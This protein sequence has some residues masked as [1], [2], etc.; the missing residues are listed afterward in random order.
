MIL[1][2]NSKKIYSSFLY[3]AYYVIKN[4]NELND[5]NYFP[6]PDGDTGTNLSSLMES[7]INKSIEEV[8]VADTLATISDAALIGSKGNSGLIFS[9]FIY[10]FTKVSDKEEMDQNIFIKAVK[11]GFI[12]AYQSIEKPVEGTMISAMRSF[13]ESLERNQDLGIDF[14]KNIELSFDNLKNEVSK[15]KEK[16]SNYKKNNIEDAGAKGFYYFIEG[17]ISVLFMDNVDL[18][19]VRSLKKIVDLPFSNEKDH[20]IDVTER[21]CT[22]VLIRTNASKHDVYK[23]V[24]DLGNSLVIGESRTIKRIHL[25]TNNPSAVVNKLEAFGEVLE[26]KIDDMKLQTLNSGQKKKIGLLVDSIADIP[27]DILEKNDVFIY[28]L[29]ILI[30]NHTYYDKLTIDNDK[31]YEVMDKSSNYPKSSSPNTV[32]LNKMY[33]QMLNAFEKVIVLSVS[34]KMSSTYE[35][36]KRESKKFGDKIEVIDTLQNSVAEGL[37]VN[38]AIELI[39]QNN[40]F[41]DIVRKIKDFRH[42]VKILVYVKTLKYMIRSGRLKKSIGFIARLIRLKPI[43][44]IDNDGEGIIYK[45][46]IGNYLV[47]KKIISYVKKLAEKNDFDS[48]AI[49]HANNLKKALKFE[50]KIKKITGLP[51]LYISDISSIIAMNSG[52]GSVGIGVIKKG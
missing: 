13:S 15:T 9:Q 38:H 31:F 12:T 6:V 19:P 21:Y 27:K 40:S 45:K 1:T 50:N 14:K 4:A 25:H 10:G 26:T 44:S 39:N 33:T 37:I 5:I 2:L 47:E 48:Y 49:V 20:D 36:F 18:S 52:V 46:T 11:E 35:I 7:V 30:D 41:T 23:E 29:A 3:G 28:N 8:S 24:K 42:Q 51:A 16:L 43:I 32:M 34:S 17:F 22:E